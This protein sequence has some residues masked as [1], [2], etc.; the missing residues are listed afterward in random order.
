MS[1]DLIA[2]PHLMHPKTSKV[3]SSQ[4]RQDKSIPTQRAQLLK[5]DS[6]LLSQAPPL[7]ENPRPSF[8]STHSQRNQLSRQRD[9]MNSQSSEESLESSMDGDSV[10]EHS[11]VND[12]LA[13]ATLASGGI[14]SLRLS[15]VPRPITIRSVPEAEVTDVT[16]TECLQPPPNSP[17]KHLAYAHAP[18]IELLIPGTGNRQPLSTIPISTQL[19]AANIVSHSRTKASA[20]KSLSTTTRQQS[21]SHPHLH[22]CDTKRLLFFRDVIAKQTDELR[23]LHVT[24][25]AACSE[26]SK[27]FDA[28]TKDEPPE[29]SGTRVKDI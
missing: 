9:S 10:D 5:I 14:T 26:R 1:N 20:S 13:N 2:E 28:L 16:T 15:S 29:P 24:L 23:S 7:H 4:V 22:P 18:T 6:L 19:S 11:S 25:L 3:F 12:S 21:N 27:T 17:T 8:S